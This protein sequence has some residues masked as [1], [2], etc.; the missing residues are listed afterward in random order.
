MRDERARKAPSGLGPTS[1]YR[2]AASGHAP[3]RGCPAQCRPRRP[4]PLQSI[5]ARD[6]AAADRQGLSSKRRRLDRKSTRSELQ[7]LMRI[8]YA[9]FCLKKKTH[10]QKSSKTP[11]SNYTNNTETKLNH[12]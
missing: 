11:K 3:S 9:V 2:K 4:F 8:S 12:R 6:R 1:A 10:T 7:S 5:W